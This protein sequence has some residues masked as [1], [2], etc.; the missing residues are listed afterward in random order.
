[1]KIQS[2]AVIFVLIILPISIVLSEYVQVQI[3]TLNVQTAYDSQLLSA[4]YDAVVA[5]QK[6][7]VNSWSSDLSSSKIRD[8]EASANVFL[9]SVANNFK[10]SGNSKDAIKEYIPAIV[11]TLYDGYYIY[12]PFFNKIEDSGIAN[13]TYK[14]GEKTYG[15]KPYIYYSREYTHGSDNFVITYSLDNYITIQGKIRNK[16]VND[17]GYLID[18]TDLPSNYDGSMYKGV[19]IN[20]G[21]IDKVTQYVNKVDYYQC[22]KINGVKYYKDGESIFSYVGNGNE[23]V[24]DVGKGQYFNNFNP[25]REYYRKAYEFTKRVITD[26]GLSNLKSENS[27]GYEENQANYNIFDVNNIE[28]YNSGFNQERRAVIKY[29]IEK[30]LSSAIANYN[31]FT[32]TTT[33]FQMPR[34]KDDEWD[35]IINNVSVISFLQG[36]N[37][38]TRQ[39]NGYSIVTN[40]KNE[41]VVAENSIYITAGDNQYHRVNDTDLLKDGIALKQGIFNMNFERKSILTYNP[42]TGE[43]ENTKYFYPNKEY[44]CYNS[45]VNQSNVDS[46][47]DSKGIPISIYEYLED[48]KEK[49]NGK[50]LASLYYTALGRERWGMYRVN[51]PLLK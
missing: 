43:T 33:N 46:M 30:N 31:N 42:D 40:N 17:S 25:A 39:Y 50:T 48:I 19:E 15:L 11:Y 51:N 23:K 28:Y 9:N 29:A 5:F 44:A 3:D 24:E 8:I 13:G 34:L 27:I 18:I 2:L 45:I 12:S 6:N 7:T 49:T 41:E 16:Y 14:D 32:T 20:D 47:L 36:L 1:M 22:V 35:N 4:T 38:G 26:Y 21:N 10:M 37:M